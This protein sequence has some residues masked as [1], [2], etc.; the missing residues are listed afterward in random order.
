MMVFMMPL[1]PIVGR[2]VSVINPF[3]NHFSASQAAMCRDA[4]VRPALRRGWSRTPIASTARERSK[5]NREI[6][7][8]FFSRTQATDDLAALRGELGKTQALGLW[9]VLEMPRKDS[10]ESAQNP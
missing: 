1:C 2:S 4:T 8:R 10:A 6:C 3:S 9:T 7:E 5:Q